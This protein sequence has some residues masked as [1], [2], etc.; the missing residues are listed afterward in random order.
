[1]RYDGKQILDTNQHQPG[2]AQSDHPNNI[3]C[4]SPGL[5]EHD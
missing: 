1:M 4:I 3:N 2:P 5:G